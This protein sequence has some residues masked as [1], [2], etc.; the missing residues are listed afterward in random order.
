MNHRS[1][2][3]INLTVEVLGDRWS[4]IVLRD[5]MFGNRRT[6][7]ELLQQ[8]LEGIASN[9]LAARLRHLQSEGLITVASDASHKQKKIYRLTEKAIQLVPVIAQ[10]GAWGVKH[11][12]STPELG[13]RASLLADGGAPLWEDFMQ[14]LRHLHLAEPINQNAPSVL[15]RL[16]AAYSDMVRKEQKSE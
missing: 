11:T 9:I 14:E 12:A 13:I 2:C 6:Y 10:L 16:N 15:E 8:S 1:G 5:M 4:I 7:R 3:P